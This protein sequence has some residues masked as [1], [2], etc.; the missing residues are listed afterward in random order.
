MIRHRQIDRVGIFILAVAMVL[1]ILAIRSDA[2]GM[3]QD[4]TAPYQYKLLDDSRVHTLDIVIE[5]KN[6]RSMMDNAR[7]KEY[8]PCTV[9]IDG[10]AYK[11]VGI[12]TKGNSSLSQVEHMDSDRYSFKIEF[13]HYEAGKSY[14]GLDKLSLNNIV[15]DTT[16]LKDYLCYHLMNQMDIAAPLS[17]FVM[18]TVNGTEFGFYLAVEGVEEALIARNYGS[19]TGNLYKPDNM[20]MGNG[21]MGGRNQD[22]GVTL[23]YTDDDPDSYSTIWEGA[24]FDYT[25]ADQ[26]RLIQSLR[27]L[28]SGENLETAI[29]VEAVLRYFV[30]H[31][32]VLNFDSYTGSMNHNYYLYERDGLLSMI[33][34]DYNL[35]FG[36]FAG[37][38]GEGNQGAG[39]GS[40]VSAMINYPI[41]TPTSGATL[42]DRPML[43]KLLE[44][45]EYLERYH[46]LFN[47]LISYFESGLFGE[48]FDQ[49]VALISPYVEQDPSSF[50][51]HDAFLKGAE[52]LRAFCLLRAESVRGQL[53]GV[54]PAT[55][56]GQAADSSALIDPGDI[57]LSDMGSMGGGGRQEGGF[58]PENMGFQ[59]ERTTENMGDINING[60]LMERT[61]S[62]SGEEGD[63]RMIPPD[64]NPEEVPMP[65]EDGAFPTAPPDGQPP[66]DF[67]N[68]RPGGS[69]IEAQPEPDNSST[70]ASLLGGSIVTLALGI[71]FV[72]R[73]R[74]F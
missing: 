34:W 56:D 73:Y 51:G 57:S 3:S 58:A 19:V 7:D 46:R 8:M 50:Y 10:E 42:E 70:V 17:S 45:P 24:V 37:M 49:V 29:D 66:G 18:I 54:I 68:R 35:A 13:D 22:N 1:S 71:L 38:G 4:R 67:G 15:Q 21:N 62:A 59:Q 43:G 26:Q 31:N 44:K 69:G 36:S 40:S 14:Y 20:Q 65:G 6:W 64:G 47:G 52:S 53:D 32:F 11:N 12:R 72:T 9:V 23:T 30:A 55:S 2:L 63:G 5:E 48:E 74:R 61:E 41:D 27:Q 16:Y 28:D 39:S 33:P 25:E 60:N